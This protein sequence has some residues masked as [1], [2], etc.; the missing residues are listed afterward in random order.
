MPLCTTAISSVVNFPE[1]LA[2][3]DRVVAEDEHLL[4]DA[5]VPER[6][7]KAAAEIER[8]WAAQRK[9][10]RTCIDCGAPVEQCECN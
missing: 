6:L 9:A 1:L 8:R 3:V 4:L 5:D 10:P 2:A 7:R